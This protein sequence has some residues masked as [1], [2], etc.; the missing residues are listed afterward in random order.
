LALVLGGGSS[1]EAVVGYDALSNA[2]VA[3]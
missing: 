1:F 3:R 2:F